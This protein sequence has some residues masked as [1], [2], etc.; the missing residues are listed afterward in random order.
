M[1]IHFKSATMLFSKLSADRYGIGLSNGLLGQIKISNFKLGPKMSDIFSN[2]NC[3]NFSAP[4]AMIMHKTVLAIGN[5]PRH[6]LCSKLALFKM[7]WKMWKVL[8]NLSPLGQIYHYWDL[9]NEVLYDPELQRV[10]KIRLVKVETP[11]FTT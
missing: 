9:S 7:A 3:D 6:Y 5:R 2:S 11:E 4:W 1:I 10:S 8:P